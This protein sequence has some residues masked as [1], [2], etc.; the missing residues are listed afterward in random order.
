MALIS[1]L[2]EL[3]PF[4]LLATRKW[5]GGH[6]VNRHTLDNWLKSKKLV[7]LARGVLVRP[8]VSVT[9][10]GVLVSLNRMAPHSVYVGGLSA[11]ELA[12]FGHYLKSGQHIHIYSAEPC[13]R[14]LNKLAM[15]VD[16]SWHSSQR[17]WPAKWLE[18][19]KTCQPVFWREGLPDYLR[20]SPEQAYLEALAYVPEQL[21]FEHADELLQGLT[22]LS[23]RRLNVLLLACQSVKVKRLFMWFARRHQYAWCSKLSVSDYDFGSG[24]RVVARGGKLDKEFLITV[25][26]H[27]YGNT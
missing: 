17:L 21:S 25:P 9:W 12:G 11:L 26:V 10:Q 27:M 22:S 20:A 2:D 23:P 18:S 7:P 14:W 15:D 24:K 1:Q 4:G 3:L 6:G 5:F 13:P 19:A 16:F 8:E